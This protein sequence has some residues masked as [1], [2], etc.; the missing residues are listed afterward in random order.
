MVERVDRLVQAIGRQIGITHPEIDA[1]VDRV[2]GLLKGNR[3][4][5]A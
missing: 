3:R 1:T 5:A 2:D 4:Q